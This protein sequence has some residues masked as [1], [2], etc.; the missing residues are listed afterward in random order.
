MRK[1]DSAISKVMYIISAVIFVCSFLF[2]AYL[3][4][5]A[6]MFLILGM[7]FGDSSEKNKNI[8]NSIY[9]DKR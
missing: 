9:R 2:G 5:E 3:I 6:G 1:I 8:D 7:C 4:V